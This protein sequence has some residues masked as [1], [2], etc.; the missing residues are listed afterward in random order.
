MAKKAIERFAIVPKLSYEVLGLEHVNTYSGAKG[1]QVRYFYKSGDDFLFLSA[2]ED[3]R[4]GRTDLR[5]VRGTGTVA[6]LPLGNRL[7]TP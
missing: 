5:K 7:C 1:A 6:W 4:A 3:D 2:M